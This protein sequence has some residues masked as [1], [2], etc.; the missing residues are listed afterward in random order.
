MR[1]PTLRPFGEGCCVPRMM[2]YV[3]EAFHIAKYER[4]PVVL[5]IPYDLHA[6]DLGLVHR[7][8]LIGLV[9]HVFDLLHPDPEIVAEAVERLAAANR[10]IILEEPTAERLFALVS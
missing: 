6:P 3:R 5:G 4:R 2:D 10:P 8:G 9:G 1:M 7:R